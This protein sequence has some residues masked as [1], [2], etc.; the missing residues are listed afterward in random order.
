MFVVF[1]PLPIFWAL[2]DQQGSRWTSQAQQLNGRIGSS[3]TIKPDQFQ[4]IN[5]IFIVALVPLFDFV[6][7]PLFSKFNLLNT[8]LQRMAIGLVFAIVAFC[9]AA[10]LESQMQA[11]SAAFNPIDRIR[12][13]NLSP[14]NIELYSNDLESKN[15]TFLSI[16]SNKPVNMPSYLVDMILN[17]NESIFKLKSVCNNHS[18]SIENDL[19]LIAHNM[20]KNVILYLENN[21]IKSIDY[22]YDITNQLIGSSEI[23]FAKFN[24]DDNFGTFHP[25]IFNKIIVYDS[26]KFIMANIKNQNDKLSRSHKVKSNSS[27]LAIDY[28]EYTLNARNQTGGVLL[29][30]KF[31]V[32]ACGRYTILFY[33]NPANNTNLDYILLTDIYPNGLHMGWQIIQ[34]FVMTIGEVMFSISGIS[35]AYSQAPASMK[36]VLQALWCLTVAFGNLIVVIVAEAKFVDNQVYEY[37]LFAGLLT[38]ATIAF[39][40]L[41]WLYK[42]KEGEEDKSNEILNSDADLKARESYTKRVGHKDSTDS[43]IQLIRMSALDPN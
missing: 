5:P 3:F 20:P 19:I 24:T 30:G 17:K 8:Q 10:V 18:L 38:V 9:I 12:I 40:V 15:G 25:S 37:I 27:Y 31:S 43:D 11:R 2:Y 34:I 22:S 29:E 33:P 7:Y 14:C 4:A 39:I 36:S 26:S 41:S 16:H 28:T 1:L 21:R 35:F 13:I 32:E 42:Y 23:K 6:I